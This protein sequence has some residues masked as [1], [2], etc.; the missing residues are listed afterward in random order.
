MKVTGIN[1]DECVQFMLSYGHNGAIRDAVCRE[2]CVPPHKKLQTDTPLRIG[3]GVHVSFI[4]YILRQM[5]EESFT[6]TSL[7][8]RECVGQIRP[9]SQQN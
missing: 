1:E 4:R 3:H 2:G 7:N 6:S 9:Q 5:L 8:I